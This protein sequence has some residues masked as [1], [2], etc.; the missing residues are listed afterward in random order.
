TDGFENY[1][2]IAIYDPNSMP[3]SG[4]LPADVGCANRTGK[5]RCGEAIVK[6]PFFNFVNVIFVI[7]M[8][9][10]T[11]IALTKFSVSKK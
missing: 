9:G 5:R 4:L 2:H 1:R 11:Y 3:V 7:L 6:V 10:L 8:I